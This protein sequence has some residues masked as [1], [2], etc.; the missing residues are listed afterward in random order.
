MLQAGIGT[1]KS[2]EAMTDPKDAM[3]LIVFCPN[4]IGDVVMATPTLRALR[5]LYPESRLTGLMRPYVADVLAGN[6][7]LDD[8]LLYD[9]RSSDPALKTTAV[10][11]R[12]RRSH[13]DLAVLLTNSLRSALLAWLGKAKRRVGYAREARSLLLTDALPALRGPDGYVP[14]PVIDY[15]LALAY[16]LG[17]GS[18]SYRMELF[19][20]E[21]DERDADALWQRLGFSANDR[22]V[23]L[24]PGAAYGSAKRWPSESFASLAGRL[25]QLEGIKVLVLSGPKERGFARFIADRSLRPRL[26][27]SMA[28]ERISIGLSKAIVR[29]A[30]LLISTDSGP[31]H[32]GAAFE[33]PV[34]SLF[35]PT[36]I[37]WTETYY[38]QE[39]KLQ[40]RLPCGPCQERVCP[41][42][43]L[44]C[45]HGLTVEEVY[46]AALGWLGLA[47]DRRA[48][49]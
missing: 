31:R 36:H 22:V 2:N 10:I 45:M 30:A 37:E 20:A 35:G 14:S 46:S 9:H 7:W 38:S 17:A 34:V 11:A 4:W 49:G 25:V 3:N 5:K 24:N 15:Y 19:V 21:E 13:F 26:V 8:V 16:H 47:A 42:G 23:V 39:T 28:E 40:K 48:A 27:K 6:P 1:S 18:E 32:F 12:L 43:H 33:T 41:L 29:R 44:Q